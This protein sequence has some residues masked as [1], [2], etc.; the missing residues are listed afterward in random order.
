MNVVV[1]ID[2][3]KGSLSSWEC[4]QAAAEGVKKA[5]SA[6]NVRVFPV[7]DGGE[8]TITALCDG[9]NGTIRQ[10]RV[11]GPLGEQ[12]VARYG[13]LP[14]GTAVIEMAEAAGLTLVKKELR[15]PLNTTTYGVGELI[16]AAALEGCRDFIAGIGGSATNDGG[17]GML[18]AL[19]V[20]FFTED[21]KRAGIF[22]RDLSHITAVDISELMPTLRNCRFKIACDVTN[23]LC[24][25]RG[26]SAVFAPQKGAT[27]QIV[28]D[29]DSWLKNFATVCEKATGKFG[30][31][32]AEGAGAAGGLGFALAVFLS[33]ET[34]RG[35]NI[36][37]RASGIETAMADA[38]VVI[39]GE[40]CLD[41]QS[42]MGK[43]P[44]GIAALAKKIN[45]AVVVVAVCGA[46]KPEAAKIHA[47][48]IDA[49]FPILAA[50]CPLAEAMDKGVAQMNLQRTAEE[51]IRL[52]ERL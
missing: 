39:T 26:C 43:A 3:F 50:P 36:V 49:Y 31:A 44:V 32:I 5:L 30:A 14:D 15:N 47:H 10:K 7:A 24:G 1:A 21:G 23:P 28:R 41:E 46:A 52:L 40:G 48:G 20:K 9:L 33:G 11:I 29:M 42:A 38:D 27:E 35:V 45:P 13:V 17:L 37:L 2:S 51:I 25:E 19:G 18:S 22:G 12:V 34:E 16:A 8:G 4:G 6:A